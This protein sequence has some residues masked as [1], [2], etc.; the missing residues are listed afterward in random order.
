MLRTVGGLSVALLLAFALPARARLPAEVARVAR[1]DLGGVTASTG[2]PQGGR[3]E[4]PPRPRAGSEPAL[5]RAH[6]APGSLDFAGQVVLG[7]A[8][9]GAQA[10]GATVGGRGRTPPGLRSG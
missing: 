4:R 7:R 3:V 9:P 2:H 5:G 1:A 10:R 6:R 8:A